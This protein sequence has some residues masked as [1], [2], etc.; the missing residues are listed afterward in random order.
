MRLRNVDIR[1]ITLS[2]IRTVK[3]GAPVS[4]RELETH[5]LAGGRVPNCVTAMLGAARGGRAVAWETVAAAD[6]EGLDVLSLTREALGDADTAA[7]AEPLS[8]REAQFVRAVASAPP[9]AVA[10]GL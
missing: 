1:T 3:G 4:V 10:A 8:P 2:R 5:W 9:A 6:L 7:R